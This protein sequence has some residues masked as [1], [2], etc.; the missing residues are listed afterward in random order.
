MGGGVPIQEMVEGALISQKF[1][2]FQGIKA[3]QAQR[4]AG[5]QKAPC[6]CMWNLF[7]HNQESSYVWILPPHPTRAASPWKED[8]SDLD[9]PHFADSRCIHIQHTVEYMGHQLRQP[10][11]W[12]VIRRDEGV[13]TWRDGELSEMEQG[14]G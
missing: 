7:F 1:K 12:L 9:L 6:K 2:F 3:S 13:E 8:A 10:S 11:C 4:G 5:T 14:L